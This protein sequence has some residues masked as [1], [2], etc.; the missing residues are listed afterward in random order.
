MTSA[1]LVSQVA[2]GLV[3][4]AHSESNPGEGG[5]ARLVVGG[6]IAPVRRLALLDSH[7]AAMDT[8]RGITR[9]LAEA[10]FALA[11]LECPLTES[12]YPMPKNGPSLRA[13]GFWASAL[14]ET[15]LSAVSLANNHIMDYGAAGLDDT[16]GACASAGLLATGAGRSRAEARQPLVVDVS[17][18]RVGIAAVADREFS[19]LLADDAG[20]ASTRE[21]DAVLDV[22]RLRGH[23]DFA[24]V[25]LHCGHEYFGLPSPRIVRLCCNLV[26]AGADAVVCHHSHVPGPMSVYSGAPVIFGC[27][28]LLFDA[29]RPQSS[30]WHVGYLVELVVRRHTTESVRLVP[31]HQCLDGPI[32]NQCHGRDRTAILDHVARL[33]AVCADHQSLAAAWSAFVHGK[34][35]GYLTRLLSLTRVEARLLSLG[36]WPRWRLEAKN[37]ARVANL[38][39]CDAHRDLVV[40]LLR[41]RIAAKQEAPER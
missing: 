18:L 21:G 28:N 31:Y 3:T 22:H 13:S 37:L 41:R 10:D 2:S 6:D 36:L 14:R 9:L 27:G 17:G 23:V 34:Q 33:S 30:L 15:G 4:L 25:V 11:N 7:G 5:R 26:E 35:D 24:L 19:V 12:R 38:F 40:E 1:D 39:E 20:P 29:Q 32:V 8:L 16:L